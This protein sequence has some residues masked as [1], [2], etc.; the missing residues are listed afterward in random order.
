M[1]FDEDPIGSLIQI[2]QIKISDLFVAELTLQKN[3]QDLTNVINILKN[4]ISGEIISSPT[5]LI[6]LDELVEKLSEN[7]KVESNVFGFF[8][9]SYFVKDTFD[10]NLIHYVSKKELPED[11][12]IIILSATI[13]INISNN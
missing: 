1:I 7:T 3:R 8:A 4:A 2:N 6:E 9:S 12:N 5:I 11:K 13:N 10:P